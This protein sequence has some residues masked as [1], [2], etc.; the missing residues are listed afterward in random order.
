MLD[1]GEFS[2]WNIDRWDFFWDFNQKQLTIIRT[3]D[4]YAMDV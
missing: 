2:D 4:T 3:G 1:I